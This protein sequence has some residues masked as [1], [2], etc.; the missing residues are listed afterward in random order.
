ML[1][2]KEVNETNPILRALTPLMH[3]YSDMFP[4]DL[5]ASLPPMRDTQHCTDLIYGANHANRAAYRM[6]LEEHEGEGE[7]VW[8]NLIPGKNVSLA[9]TKQD[10][11]V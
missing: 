6:N 3:E 7:M 9:E 11:T 8:A 2:G 1:T 5:P 10:W 4:E